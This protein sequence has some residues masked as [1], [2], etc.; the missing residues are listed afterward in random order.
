MADVQ[1]M[2]TATSRMEA[3]AKYG[4]FIM[5]PVLE[6]N[7][8]SKLYGWLKRIGSFME[9]R[10]TMLTRPTAI[11]LAAMR[12]TAMFLIPITAGR[13]IGPTMGHT[14]QIRER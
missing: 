14:G 7:I 1:E 5:E 4:L 9:M 13:P 2:D 3:T 8:T 10:D 11:R 6:L 12:P